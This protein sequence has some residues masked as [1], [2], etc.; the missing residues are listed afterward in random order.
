MPLN[1]VPHDLR[2]PRGILHRMG[3]NPE[4]IAVLLRV[5]ADPNAQD[6]TGK[7]SAPKPNTPG[8]KL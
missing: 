8:L 1:M 7:S 6:T 2:W 3:N 4:I 5:G